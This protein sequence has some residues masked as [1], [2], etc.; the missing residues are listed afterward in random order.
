MLWMLKT[1]GQ[2]PLPRRDGNLALKTSLAVQRQVL[3]CGRPARARYGHTRHLHTRSGGEATRRR[4]LQA[5]HGRSV[6]EA[7]VDGGLLAALA[8]ARVE[9][10]EEDRVA[11][12]GELAGLQVQL[13]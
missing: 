3:P 13:G 10:R 9:R 2:R 8:A 1:D 4:L 7:D 12:V 11:A 5:G 6:V